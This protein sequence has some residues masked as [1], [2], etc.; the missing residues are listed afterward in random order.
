MRIDSVAPSAPQ[1]GTSVPGT[2]RLSSGGVGRNI[3]EGAARILHGPG[4]AVAGKA[5]PKGRVLV[6]MVRSE[7]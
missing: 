1:P 4:I 2:V 7:C 5:F 6:E 3:A